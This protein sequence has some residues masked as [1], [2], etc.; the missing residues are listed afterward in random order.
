MRRRG[1]SFTV[2]YALLLGPI[3]ACPIVATAQSHGASIGGT[4]SGVNGPS[5]INTKDDLK[6]FHDAMAVQATGPQ[7]TEYGALVKNTQAANAALQALLPGK[8]DAAEFA[9]RDA[10]LGQALGKARSDNKKFVD[11]FSPEQ[12]S[13]LKEFTKRLAKADSDVALELSK[14]DQVTQVAKSSP[15]ITSHVQSLD[16]A[17]ADF[18]NQQLALGREMGII[19]ANGQDVTFALPEVTSPVEI[20]KRKITVAVSGEL[21]QI[22]AE[23]GQRTF[24]LKRAAN[25]SDLQQNI[26]ELMAGQLD[27]SETCGQRVA[28]RQARLTPAAPASLLVVRLHFER[29]ACTRAMGQQTSNELAEGDGT[30]EVKLTA[31]VDKSEL[32]LTSEIGRIGASG[33]LAESLRSGSLGEDLR[34]K[35]TQLLLSTMRPAADVKTLPPAVQNSTTLQSAKFQD[36]G[37]GIL[38]VALAGQVQISNDQ[39][40]QLASQLNQALSAQGTA[41]H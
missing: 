5:G 26:L 38:R 9:R 18:S 23:N 25:L 40:Y 8:D 37:A 35:I 29:W 7:I 3:L 27:S 34:D 30:V 32:K 6:D 17:L 13:L 12:K 39:A 33:M 19:L 28:I 20:G 41:G 36:A 10:A 22:A 15:E 14:L 1:V 4:V 21:S 16:K 24:T 11:E 2:I 31:A